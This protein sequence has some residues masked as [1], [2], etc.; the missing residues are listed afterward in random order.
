MIKAV[1]YDLGDVFFEAHYWREWMYKFFK[2]AELFTG[3]FAGFYKLYEE[4]ILDIY[5]GKNTYDEK[6]LEFLNSLKIKNPYEF[7]RLSFEK[8]RYFENN[9][10]LFK[11]VKETL[12]NIKDRDIKNVI[13]TDNE[14]TEKEVREN[15]IAKYNINHLLDIIITSKDIGVTKPDPLIFKK[16]MDILKIEKEEVLFVGHDKEEINGAKELGMKT[17]EFDNYLGIETKSDYKIKQFC[18]ILNV[19][20]AINKNRC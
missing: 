10:V 6:Y 15:V 5:N 14:A 8:K 4:F 7:K 18:D 2:N 11:G 19:I 12:E 9:R 16:P 20:N 13:I 17:V 1:F 3:S